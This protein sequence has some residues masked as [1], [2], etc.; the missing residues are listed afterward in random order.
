MLLEL[1]SYPIIQILFNIL[2]I[3]YNQELIKYLIEVNIL[4]YLF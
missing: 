1:K 4:K 3:R 2:K